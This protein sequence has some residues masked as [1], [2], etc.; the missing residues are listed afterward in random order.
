MRP[1][2][3]I[4]QSKRGERVLSGIELSTAPHAID[5]Y[6]AGAN[7]NERLE[8]SIGMRVLESF[9]D[10][11]PNVALYRPLWQSAMLDSGAF[12]VMQS[13]KKIDIG[14]YREFVEE[15]GEFYDAVA[16][17][18]D[19][20]DWRRS[21]ENWVEMEDL[22]VFPVYHEGEPIDL[23]RAYAEEQTKKCGWIGI[24]AQRP[25]LPSR[26]V[27]WLKSLRD[28]VGDFPDV[29]F[30]GFGL[31]MYASALPFESADSTS[32]FRMIS[33]MRLAS[34]MDHLT[35]RELMDIIMA[36][37]ERAPLRRLWDKGWKEMLEI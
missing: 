4:D 6:L 27:A 26:C 21:M 32:W 2:C 31:V 20:L 3:L 23:L 19:I 13:G 12:S 37:L 34:F 7:S 15:H 35:S 33:K 30:H 5:L 18:D 9:A 14:E 11:K 36:R 8:Y 22:D 24:G 28:V 17:L 25:I 16:S 1:A 29:H 10:I